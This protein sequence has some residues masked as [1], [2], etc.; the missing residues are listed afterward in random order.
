MKDVGKPTITDLKDGATD[1]TRITWTPDLA[2]FGLSELDEDH[3][4]LFERR[5]YDLAGVTRVKASAASLQATHDCLMSL[6]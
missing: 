6:P 2:K 4:A 5:A 1:F 3:C